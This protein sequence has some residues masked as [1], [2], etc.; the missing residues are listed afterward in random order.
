MR[1]AEIIKRTLLLDYARRFGPKV[2]VETGTYKGDT[3]KTMAT[4]GLFTQVISMDIYEDRALHAQARFQGFPSVHCYCGD[5]AKLLPEIIATLHEPALFWLD[6]HHSGKQIARVKG[7]IETPIL[8]ELR[9]VLDFEYAG[10]SVVLID[11][12]R[13]YVDF[14]KQYPNYPN[15]DQLREMILGKFPNWVFDCKDDIIRCHRSL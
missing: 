3:V 2:F 7:L 11:D 12:Q 6:A 9:A 1:Q 10:Q 14:S 13:Y 15:L 5:S 4:S 8:A